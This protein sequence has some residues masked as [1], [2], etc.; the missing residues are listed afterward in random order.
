MLIVFKVDT[1][2]LQKHGFQ[3]L[4]PMLSRPKTLGFTP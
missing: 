3:A 1:S 4:K 2:H